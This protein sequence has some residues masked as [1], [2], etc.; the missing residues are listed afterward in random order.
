[1]LLFSTQHFLRTF[2][3]TFPQNIISREAYKGRGSKIKLSMSGEVTEKRR[4]ISFYKSLFYKYL[5]KKEKDFP[6]F[7][8]FSIIAPF[9][10]FIFPLKMIFSE[11]GE[12][13]VL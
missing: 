9:P 12:V 4:K 13:T 2:S 6:L 11:L 3:D 7:Y 1:M 10:D 8:E 5:E